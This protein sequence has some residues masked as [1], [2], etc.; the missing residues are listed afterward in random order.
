M[1]SL[2]TDFTVYAYICFVFFSLCVTKFPGLCTYAYRHR[3]LQRCI[4]WHIVRLVYVGL[5]KPT[6]NAPRSNDCAII[7]FG[8]TFI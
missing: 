1:S 5:V 7:S 3:D 4:E 8:R 2:A 6:E